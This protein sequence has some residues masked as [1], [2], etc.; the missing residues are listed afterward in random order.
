MAMLRDPETGRVVGFARGGELV[1][2]DPEGRMDR[3][4]VL[5]SDGVRSRT[6][7]RR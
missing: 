5:L 7:E 2:L 6:A 1:A 4:E 3:L